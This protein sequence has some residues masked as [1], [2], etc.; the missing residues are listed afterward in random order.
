MKRTLI[1]KEPTAKIRVM[2]THLEISTFYETQYVGFSQMTSAY[3]HKN[4]RLNI[5][6]AIRIAE[7][8]PLYFIDKHG[9]IL[10]KICIRG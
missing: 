5:S 9:N 4:V 8:V 3:I 7:H 10:G 2:A 1:V 6:E